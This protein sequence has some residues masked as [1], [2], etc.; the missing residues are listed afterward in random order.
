MVCLPG[1]SPAQVQLRTGQQLAINSS[2]MDLGDHAIP[3]VADWNNDGLPDLLVGYQPAFK[4]AL[5]LNSGSPGHP[6][7]SNFINVVAGSSDV[8]CPASGCGS[9]A[10]FVCDYDQDGRKDLLVGSGADGRIWFFKNTNTDAAPILAA[11]VLLLL[12]NAPLSVGIRSTPY[13]YDWDGDQA[14]DLLSGDGLGY[15]HFFKNTGTA[16]K[17]VYETDVLVQAGGA[18]VNFSSRSCIRVLDWD[19]DGRPDLLGSGSDNIAWCRN[20]SPDSPP[21]LNAPVQLKAPIPVAGLAPIDTGYRMRFEILDWNLDGVPDILMGNADG[22]LTWYAGYRFSIRRIFPSGQG[23]MTL[24]WDS[25]D[26]LNYT[27]SAGSQPANP[28]Q[29]VAS[30]VASGGLTTSWTHTP[31]APSQFYRVSIAP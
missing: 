29:V 12:N 31:T 28:S 25:A 7:Y 18:S 1:A 22:T 27:I 9:P 4:V 10:P 30:K 2:T 16:Q 26:N 5:Y 6:A 13:I 24:E 11:G 20:T 23:Q 19:G 14:P 8:Y 21:V 15:V 17:P 3:C